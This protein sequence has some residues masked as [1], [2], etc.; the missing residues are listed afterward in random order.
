MKMNW[1]ER[2]RLAVGAVLL[3][4]ALFALLAV[5]GLVSDRDS[6]VPLHTAQKAGR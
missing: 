3:A 5:P 4:A 2:L 1:N 6:T